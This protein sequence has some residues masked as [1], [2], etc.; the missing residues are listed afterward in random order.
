VWK[1]LNYQIYNFLTKAVLSTSLFLLHA[2]QVKE[3]LLLLKM[4]YTKKEKTY[5][6]PLFRD[7]CF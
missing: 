4:Q 7:M 1:G 5:F 3:R 6:S 2:E